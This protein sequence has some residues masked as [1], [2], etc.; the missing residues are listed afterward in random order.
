MKR[1]LAIK[2]CAAHAHALPEIQTSSIACIDDATL[3]FDESP[4]GRWRGNWSR[5]GAFV[6]SSGP[7]A[8]PR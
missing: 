3:C 7:D 8:H 2:R 6:T 5:C 1:A 4:T